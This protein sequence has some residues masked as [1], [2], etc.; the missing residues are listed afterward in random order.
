MK[1]NAVTNAITDRALLA[2]EIVTCLAATRPAVLTQPKISAELKVERRYL[3]PTLQR[4][5][6][7]GIISSLRGPTG[8][9]S[10]RGDPKHLSAALIINLFS[11]RTKQ[12]ISPIRRALVLTQ[13]NALD[14]VS[15][16][17]L[18]AA[19]A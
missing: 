13:M 5:A 17:E 12:G 9:Y 10:Y 18:I 11:P 19:T 15:V 1:T 8:G 7:S 4:L 14:R 3:E 2:V 6:K 16:A